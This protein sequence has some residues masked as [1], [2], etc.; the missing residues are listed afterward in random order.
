MEKRTLTVFLIVVSVFLIVFIASC[1][2]AEKSSVLRRDR[3]VATEN[4]Q[5]R[6]ELKLSQK[7]IAMQLKSLDECQKENEK[8]RKDAD[9]AVAF[10]IDLPEEIVNDSKRLTKE[11]HELKARIAELQAKVVEPNAVAR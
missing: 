3:L 8:T 5:L 10:L 11:N 2:Q 9:E 7:I 4:I 1:Q 6:K